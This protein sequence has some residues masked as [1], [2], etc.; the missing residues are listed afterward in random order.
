MLERCLQDTTTFIMVCLSVNYWPQY[1]RSWQISKVLTCSPSSAAQRSAAVWYFC[2]ISFPDK[3]TTNSLGSSLYSNYLVL[4]T[5]INWRPFFP[6]FLPFIDSFTLS[7]L[8]V[9]SP[10]LPLPPWLTKV[11]K[12]SCRFPLF[13]QF[14]S[15]LNLLSGGGRLV[16]VRF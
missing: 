7:P 6:L 1:L 15:P 3:Q 12:G 8:A 16:W 9:A 4:F 14:A 11:R 5:W 13:S 10:S 2:L